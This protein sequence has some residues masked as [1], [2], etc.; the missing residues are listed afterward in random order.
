MF[1]L[2]AIKDYTG[3]FI[4]DTG[5]V[6]CNLGKGCRNK[7]SAVTKEL[8][9]IKARPNKNGYLRVYLRHDTTW[10]RK[11]LY[12]HRLV[13]KYFIPNPDNKPHVNHKNCNVS[14]NRVEN[15]EWCTPKENTEYAMLVGHVYRDLTNGRFISGL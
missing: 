8:Y 13:A 1:I 5:K 2:K 4:S 7:F 3:Y 10:R 11:D 15:L 12:V 6:Y 14:D 9:E